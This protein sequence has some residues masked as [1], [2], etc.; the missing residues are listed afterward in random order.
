MAYTVYVIYSSSYNKIYIGYTSDL[1]GRL[2]SHNEL[3]RKGWTI[4]FRPWRLLYT[5][6]Y[7][8]KQDAM[9]REKELKSARGRLFIR[10]LIERD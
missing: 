4:A 5:E 1:E 6:E 2:L 9:R 10:A 8:R 3:G 7:S